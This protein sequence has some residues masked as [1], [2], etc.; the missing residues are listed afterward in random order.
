MATSRCVDVRG[1]TA[2]TRAPAIGVP[3]ESVTYPRILPVLVCDKA[4][5]VAVTTKARLR[6]N[7]RPRCSNDVR[8]ISASPVH[9]FASLITRTLGF[10]KADDGGIDWE[11]RVPTF[12]F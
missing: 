10:V 4:A 6:N 11:R 12:S 7:R 9:V 8:L 1:F 5:G 3:P 2:T